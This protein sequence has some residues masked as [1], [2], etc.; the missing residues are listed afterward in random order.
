MIVG[1]GTDIVYIS[2]FQ[3]AFSQMG[4]KGKQRLFTSAEQAY[5]AARKTLSLQT[6]AKRFAAKEAVAKALGTGIGTVSWTQIEVVNNEQGAPAVQ[7]SGQAAELLA[8]KG[9]HPKIHLSLSD[10]GDYALAFVVI[11]ADAPENG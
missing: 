8:S 7:L 10:D 11:E 3:Q 4:E 9:N 2:H 1:I 5:A 6:Y